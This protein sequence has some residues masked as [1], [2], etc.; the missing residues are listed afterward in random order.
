MRPDRCKAVGPFAC[1]RDFVRIAWLILAGMALI[2][3]S[4]VPVQALNE[5]TRPFGFRYA[6]CRDAEVAR[7]I[8][9][10][11]IEV[12]QEVRT[13]RFRLFRLLSFQSLVNLEVEPDRLTLVVNDDGQI[14]R[15]FCR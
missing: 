1:R 3:V 14:I 7:F 2:G 13:A 5:P 6:S 10:D 4:S 11:K 15:A 9:Q 12:L 8:G